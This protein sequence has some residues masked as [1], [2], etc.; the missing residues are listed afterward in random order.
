[1]RVADRRSVIYS[2]DRIPERLLSRRGDHALDNSLYLMLDRAGHAVARA[3]A[4]LSP[5][6]RRRDT[7]PGG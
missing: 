5:N 4:Q 6:A 7:S 2:R 3:T 1:M